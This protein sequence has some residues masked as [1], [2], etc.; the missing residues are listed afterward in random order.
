M[1]KWRNE[2]YEYSGYLVLGQTVEELHARVLGEYDDLETAQRASELAKSGKY[3][4]FV[5]VMI[6]EAKLI[7]KWSSV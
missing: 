6:V 7:R 2:K 5:G 1:A 3:G 4:E